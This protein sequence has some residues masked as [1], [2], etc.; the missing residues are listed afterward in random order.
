MARLDTGWH[1]HPK[2]LALGLA[3]MGLHA[4]S[5]S[6]CDHALTDGFIPAGAW[7]SLLGVR[8]AVRGLVQAGLW[9]P[10]D[11]GYCLHD[12]ADYNRTKAQ[13]EAEREEN[14]VRKMSGRNPG[15]F[16]P[17]SGRVSG[18]IPRAPGPGPGNVVNPAGSGSSPARTRVLEADDPQLLAEHLTLIARD[19]ASRGL[20]SQ[21]DSKSS[22][23]GETS[24]A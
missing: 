3:G 11:G 14:R 5:I 10:T 13:V 24:G 1:V 15:Q 6:Y 19:R 2:V 18:R 4:W 9:V 20:P 17:E 22:E 7:P 21:P 16:R 12:Y 8:A 23:N